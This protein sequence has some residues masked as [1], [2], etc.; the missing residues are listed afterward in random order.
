MT[1]HRRRLHRETALFLI[2]TLGLTYLLNAGMLL[3]KRFLLENPDVF[4][5]TL[6]VEMMIP[7][8]AAITVGLFIIRDS[9]YTRRPTI[10][11]VYY[12]LAAAFGAVTVLGRAFFGVEPVPSMRIASS[13]LVPG[14]VVLLG[15][16]HIKAEWRQELSRAGLGFGRLS[17]YLSFGA[18]FAG[19]FLISS[20]LNLA[21]GLASPPGEPFGLGDLV[22]GGLARVVVSTVLA[23]ILFFGEEFGWRIFLQDHL[24]A[25][26]GRT[27]G[28][29]LVGVIWGAWHAPVVAVFG[30]TYPGYPVLGPILFTILTVTLSIFLGLAVVK[31]RSVLLAAFLHGVFN[32][33]AGFTAGYI[34]DPRDP[35]VSFGVGIYGLLILAVI[36]LAVLRSKQWKAVDEL[37][38]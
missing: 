9:A 21:L 14:T 13:I 18:L 19:Y 7:A 4:V 1:T 33:T 30:W 35:V 24:T 37:A 8:F 15:A 2:L 17:T 26:L 32:N 27:R 3:R 31:S 34:A 10:F 25:L 16:L 22:L 5:Q 11:A 28:V 23:F 6:Q 12:L 29:L 36:A 20:W 38:H